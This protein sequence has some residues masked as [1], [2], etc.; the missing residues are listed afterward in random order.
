MREIYSSVE[1]LL[2]CQGRNVTNHKYYLQLVCP[3]ESIFK[4]A[5][6]TLTE[7]VV[8]LGKIGGVN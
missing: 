3:L 4:V 7:G 5:N 1:A 6:K 8:E 2:T